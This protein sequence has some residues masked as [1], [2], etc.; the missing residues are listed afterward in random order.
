ML[1][2]EFKYVFRHLIFVTTLLLVKPGSQCQIL[3]LRLDQGHQE[4]QKIRLITKSQD[5]SW[6]ILIFLNFV[7]D[8]SE[9][10]PGLVPECRNSQ[11][12]LC[13]IS[14]RPNQI[15]LRIKIMHNNLPR[16]KPD[17]LKK[18]LGHLFIH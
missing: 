7:W 1:L 9:I 10:C 2:S 11:M 14:I 12:S 17:S 6:G 16:L 8:K 5:K 13:Q 15:F 3:V 18:N 4:H